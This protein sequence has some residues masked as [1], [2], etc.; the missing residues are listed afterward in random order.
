MAS[1]IIYAQALVYF[2]MLKAGVGLSRKNMWHL[3]FVVFCYKNNISIILKNEEAFQVKLQLNGDWKKFQIRH[4]PAS[5]FS[6]FKG[7]I[8]PQTQYE[9]IQDYFKASGPGHKLNILDAGANVGYTSV[10]F[11]S[12]FPDASVIAIEPDGSNFACLKTNVELNNLKDVNLVKAG[13]WYA[14]A[15][16]VVTNTFRDKLEH[17]FTVEESATESTLK[18]LK[19]TDLIAEQGWKHIDIL[20]MDIEG[21][22]AKLFNKDIDLVNF[23]PHVK[24]FVIEI[25]DEFKCRKEIMSIFSA[26]NFSTVDFGELTYAYNNKAAALQTA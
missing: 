19:I 3:D 6:V 24:L 21:T 4:A 5:D 18:G 8:F 11:K 9:K 23:L 12:L 2:I 15:W 22:E 17:A 13:L 14:N 26:N 16:L 25:H 7:V 10:Y 1:A 20:K